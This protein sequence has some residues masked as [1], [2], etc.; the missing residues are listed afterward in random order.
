[1]KESY[2]NFEMGTASSNPFKSSNFPVTKS[3]YKKKKTVKDHRIMNLFLF[4]GK[5]FFLPKKYMPRS[6]RVITIRA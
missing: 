4:H 2:K 3:E 1:M 6:V 5:E